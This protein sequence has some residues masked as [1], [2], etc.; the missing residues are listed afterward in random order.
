MIVD[1]KKNEPYFFYF[2]LENFPN[3]GKPLKTIKNNC[4]P[5]LDP[6]LK[7]YKTKKP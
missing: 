5:W 2:F 3:E 1:K 4:P 7:I 6:T